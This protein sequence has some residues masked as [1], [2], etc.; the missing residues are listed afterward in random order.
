MK[1]TGSTPK[2]ILEPIL[3]WFQ[4]LTSRGA[5]G[6]GLK[7]VVVNVFGSECTTVHINKKQSGLPAR[8]G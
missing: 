3:D 4:V 7:A 5:A 8:R 6:N 2:T 1:K